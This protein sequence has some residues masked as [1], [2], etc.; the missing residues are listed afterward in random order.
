MKIEP[1]KEAKI[2]MG[3]KKAEHD[4]KKASKGFCSNPF[5]IYCKVN[6]GAP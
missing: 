3:I 6:L 5:C 4:T 2:R 1:S